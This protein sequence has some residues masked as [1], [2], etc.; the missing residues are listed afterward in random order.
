MLDIFHNSDVSSISTKKSVSPASRHSPGLQVAAGCWWVELIVTSHRWDYISALVLSALCH[1]YT[2]Q[3]ICNT[4][5]SYV[6]QTGHLNMHTQIEITDYQQQERWD[7]E[8]D[9]A[10]CYLIWTAAWGKLNEAVRYDDDD[11]EAKWKRMFITCCS[12]QRWWSCLLTHTQQFF[13]LRRINSFIWCV[14]FLKDCLRLQAPDRRCLWSG[15]RSTDVCGSK[16]PAY[17]LSKLMFVLHKSL[18]RH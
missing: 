13:F 7:A 16:A 17:A 6:R 15:V 12:L 2:L 9:A 4:D 10:V 18:L 5:A 8:A 1:S 3:R 11:D 14:S